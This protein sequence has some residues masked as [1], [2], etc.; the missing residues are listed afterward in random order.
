MADRKIARVTKRGNGVRAEEL[1]SIIQQAPRGSLPKFISPQ[2]AML[3]PKPPMGDRW[4]HEIR[5]G[6]D[7][8]VRFR[9]IAQALLQLPVKAAYLEGEIVVVREDGVSSFADLQEALS[10]GQA[11]RLSYYGFD[12]LHLDGRDLLEVPLRERKRALSSL[13]SSLPD[14]P[15]HYSQHL[16]GDGP[17][18]FHHACKLGLEGIISK[19]GDAPYRS[20]RGRAGRD[21][22]KVKCINRQEYIV[23][24]WA[25]SEATGRGLRSL[26]VGY[27]Q[28]GKLIFAG[29]VGTGFTERMERNLLARLERLHRPECPFVAVPKEYRE[30]AIWV[31]PQLVVAIKFTE[32]TRDGVL[33]HPSFDGV[34]EGVE[35][36]SVVLKRPAAVKEPTG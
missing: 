2:L 28:D 4:L 22:F 20:G 13:L 18:A 1:A 12:L 10:A 7:W 16:V 17:R 15:V 32:W 9:P 33:R 25:A 31:E 36:K 19:L 21:W 23:G 14:G 29:R 3:A 5:K 8:T 35:L 24:G 27:Y 6:L 30:G 34:C 26:L 11:G